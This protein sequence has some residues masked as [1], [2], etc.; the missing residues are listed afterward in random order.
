M[1][2]ELAAVTGPGTAS[3]GTPATGRLDRGA[4]GPAGGLGLDD[5]HDVGQRGDEPVPRRE[6][7][8]RGRRAERVLAQH[9]AGPRPPGATAARGRGGRCGRDRCR[10]RRPAARRRRRGRR[11]GRRRRCRGRGPRPP[12]RRTSAS[13]TTE[14]V[15]DVEPVAGGLAGADDRRPH[16]G[17]VVEVALPED[18]RRRVVVGGERGR[19]GRRARARPRRC[20]AS[21]WACQYAAGSIAAAAVLQVSNEL[22]G[23]VACPEPTTTAGST[24]PATH[25]RPGLPRAVAVEQGAQPRRAH[26]GQS[27]QGGHVGLVGQLAAGSGTG[28]RG[29]ARPRQAAAG[30]TTTP[31]SDAQVERTG[32]V[33]GLQGAV[34][35][36]EVGQGESH[37]PHPAEAPGGEPTL[38]QRPLDQGGGLRRE[39]S[40]AARARGPASSA[41]ARTPRSRARSR[42]AATRAATTAVESAGPPRQELLGI[43]AEDLEPEVEAV[44]E[45]A[46]HAAGGSARA[47][48]RC[49]GTRQG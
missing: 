14:L 3:T 34:V 30:P 23:L 43:G 1:P 24:A 25:P 7:P 35:A 36:G 28:G 9:H 10:P 20:P 13:S 16:A 26:P 12:R 41:L 45:R 6:L 39:R 5:H 37:A 48:G 21:A 40:D 27:G 11:R 46:R 44:E 8:G 19:E 4:H 33:L 2:S 18:D 31:G 17:Q 47:S 29:S 15:G 49:T 42:A 38:D 32:H 22:T